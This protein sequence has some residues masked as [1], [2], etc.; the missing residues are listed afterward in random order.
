MASIVEGVLKMGLFISDY[1]LHRLQGSVVVL[2]EKHQLLLQVMIDGVFDSG[3]TGPGSFRP[4]HRGDQAQHAAT[5]P[6]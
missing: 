2:L 3:S 4:Q 1:G 6:P 5:K